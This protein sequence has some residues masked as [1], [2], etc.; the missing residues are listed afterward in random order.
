[1]SGLRS[2]A[3]FLRFT[4]SPLWSYSRT[5]CDAVGAK[6]HPSKILLQ[7]K[8][9]IGME[10]GKRGAWTRKKGKGGTFHLVAEII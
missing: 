4:P 2:N 10:N 5:A 9:Q 8:N 3:V 7:L 6:W 1:M